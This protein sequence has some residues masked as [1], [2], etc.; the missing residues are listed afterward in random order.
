MNEENLI[1]RNKTYLGD[2]KFSN[3]VMTF[4]YENTVIKKEKNVKI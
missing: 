2:L 1:E 4:C 3:L